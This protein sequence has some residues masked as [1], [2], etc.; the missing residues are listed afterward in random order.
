MAPTSSPS[1]RSALDRIRRGLRHLAFVL[2]VSLIATVASERMF[3]F[4]STGLDEHLFVS[5]FYGVAT[6]V[7]L[8]AIDRYRVSTWWSLWLATPLFALVVEGVITPVT[9]SGGPFVPIFPAW[10]AFWHGV[11]AFGV[12]VV[13]VRHLLLARR[14]ALVAGLAAA[15]GIFWGAWSTTLWLPENVE[16]P[17]LVADQGEALQVLDP[18]DFALY[19]ALFTAVVVVGHAALGRVWPTSF[20]LSRPTL[21]VGGGLVLFGAAMWTVAIPWALPMFLAYGGLQIWG[22]RRHEQTASGPTLLE[23]LAGPTP[24]QPLLGLTVMAPAAAVT[25]ALL[26]ET[27]FSHAA[28]RALMWS[29]IAVQTVAG[30]VITVMA[31]RRAG[32]GADDASSD[33]GDQSVVPAVEMRSTSNT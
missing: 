20:A 33:A 29:T 13:G 12:L 24:V 21:R 1:S 19:A 10:F 18:G 4:W 28:A 30:F 32:R 3:W 2:V 22:L 9:Y 23:R 14:T 5:A 7:T 17:E 16:D 8:W 15:L 27:G 6:A 26:W 31:L 11:L 25:Y